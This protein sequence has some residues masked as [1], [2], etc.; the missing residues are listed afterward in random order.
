MMQK[1]S[2]YFLM[3]LGDKLIN[4]HYTCVKYLQHT[5]RK[6]LQ[7]ATTF[8]IY[9]RKIWSKWRKNYMLNT[10][11]RQLQK[12]AFQK[13]CPWICGNHVKHLGSTGV[14]C[15]ILEFISVKF[16][17]I[18]KRMLNCDISCKLKF[19]NCSEENY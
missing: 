10:F 14:S 7:L 12:S 17:N 19:Q 15:H 6:P 2:F 13:N 18:R 4:E 3:Y 8:L 9:Y 16:I 11:L 5:R 1:W